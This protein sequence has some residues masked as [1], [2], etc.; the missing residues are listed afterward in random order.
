MATDY[1]KLKLDYQAARDLAE[2]AIAGMKDEGTCNF[3]SVALF[4]V[5]KDVFGKDAYATTWRGR[6]CFLITPPGG[7]A[8]T[9]TKAAGVMTDF[10]KA[11]GWEVVTYYQMD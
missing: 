10:L 4:G 8:G 11:R 5:R 3:D 7:Q 9:R 6:K 2:K 1:E